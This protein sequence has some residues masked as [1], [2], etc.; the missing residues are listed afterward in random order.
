VENFNG[1]GITWQITENI[2]VRNCEINGCDK[3]MH[4]G[5]GSV[6]SVIEG[7]NSHHNDGDGLFVCYRVQHGLVRNNIFHHN[8]LNGINTGHKDSDMRF[9]NNHIYENAANGVFFRD[10]NA[11]NS[12]HRN[13]FINNTIE[14]NGGKKGG[15]GFA[16]YGNA[17]DVLIQDNIIRDTGSGNQI[18]AIFFNK[19]TPPV[20]LQNNTMSGHKHGNEIYG[21]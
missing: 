12:P 15:Y 6:Y 14:N 3:G 2:T 1:D 8:S 20:K 10:E 5:T 4:P 17:Q 11:S 9:E 21:R 18:G 7:N 19:G 13:T 16:L